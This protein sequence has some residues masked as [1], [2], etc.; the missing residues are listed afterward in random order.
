[1]PIGIGRDPLASFE[2]RYKSFVDTTLLA[3]LNWKIYRKLS[4]QMNESRATFLGV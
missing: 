1:M 4:C 3:A 2:K